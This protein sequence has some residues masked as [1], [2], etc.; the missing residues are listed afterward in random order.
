MQKTRTRD[1]DMGVLMLTCTSCIPL[2]SP[3][4]RLSKLTHVLNRF[5]PPRAA[6][7]RVS[8]ILPSGTPI[9]RPVGHLPASASPKRSDSGSLEDR[10]PEDLPPDTPIESRTLARTTGFSLAPTNELD[11]ELELAF[12]ISV[13]T[14]H[15][16]R[17]P[18]EKTEEHIFG[19]VLLNDWS[20]VF[21]FFALR[22]QLSMSFGHWRACLYAKY[23]RKQREIYKSRRPSP[24]EHLTRRTLRALSARG[25]SPSMHWNRSRL[26]MTYVGSH[27]TLWMREMRRMISRSA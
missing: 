22:F 1:M 17:V 19:V 12:F 27:R 15:F 4:S 25:W 20:G 24:S 16:E 5:H 9:V 13:P 10:A 3:S 23:V 8:T 2:Y 7:G 26:H 11:F 14:E 21:F 18:V 6:S